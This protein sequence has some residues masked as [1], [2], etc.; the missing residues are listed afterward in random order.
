[1]LGDARMA[2]LH[3]LLISHATASDGIVN[4]FGL[5]VFGQRPEGTLAEQQVNFLQ[6]LLV[7]LLE[8]EPDRG[9]GDDNVPSCKDKVV[10]LKY[11]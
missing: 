7:R 9:N 8:E 5:N 1:V 11:D 2:D 10:F 6:G 3:V 4:V